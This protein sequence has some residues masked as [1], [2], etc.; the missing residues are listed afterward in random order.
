MN[1]RTFDEMSCAERI[2]YVN[3]LDVEKL[4]K[5]ELKQWFQ[6]ARQILYLKDRQIERV[7][8]IQRAAQNNMDTVLRVDQY[9]A[10][11]ELDLNGAVNEL[12]NLKSDYER[13]ELEDTIW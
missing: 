8:Q 11:E 4:S 7:I 13:A 9:I 12:E 6:F 3:Y 5:D 2:Q 10:N 1:K